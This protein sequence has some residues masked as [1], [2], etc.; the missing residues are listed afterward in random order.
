ME[1]EHEVDYMQRL[2]ISHA[3]YRTHGQLFINDSRAY[4]HINYQTTVQEGEVLFNYILT[5][6]VSGIGYMIVQHASQSQSQQPQ[7]YTSYQL[8]LNATGK[9]C[10]SRRLPHNRTGQQGLLLG[11]WLSFH[12]YSCLDSMAW[13]AI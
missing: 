8:A 9:S 10:H 5:R 11:S 1:V 3:M 7:F 13:I 2:K 4:A 12:L 6:W